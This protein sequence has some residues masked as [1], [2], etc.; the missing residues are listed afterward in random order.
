MWVENFFRTHTLLFMARQWQKTANFSWNFDLFLTFFLDCDHIYVP[1][2]KTWGST[3]RPH[4]ALFSPWGRPFMTGDGPKMVNFGQKNAKHG[5]LVSTPKWS[6]R[7]QKGPKWSPKCFDRLGPLLGPSGPFWTISDNWTSWDISYVLIYHSTYICPSWF[8]WK[9]ILIFEET[10]FF[11]SKFW[12]FG[13]FWPILSVP[14]IMF[15]VPENEKW[16]KL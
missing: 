1:N 10:V 13:S 14:K 15:Q 12:I 16:N 7:V 9:E 5:R 11:N 4:I 6:K 2:G 8:D 3:S